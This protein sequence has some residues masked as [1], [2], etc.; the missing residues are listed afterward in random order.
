VSAKAYAEEA[1]RIPVAAECDVLVAGGGSAGIAAAVAASRAGAETILVERYGSLGGMATGGLVILLLSLDD[2]CG[3]QTVGGLCQELVDR[4]TARS[5]ALH[6][7]AEQWGNPDLELVEHYR[8][9]GLVWGREP[10]AV[11]YSVAYDPEEFRFAA[12]GLLAEAGV[13]LRL[14]TWI[15]RPIV[16]DGAVQGVIT[17]SKAGREAFLAKVVVDATGDGDLFAAAGE[18]FGLEQVHPWLWFRMGNVR[19]ADDAILGTEGRFFKALGGRFFKTLGAGRTLMPWGIADVVDRKIDPTSPDDLTWA[20]L[21]CRRRVMAVVDELK[22]VEGFEDAYLE[23]LA[24]QLGIYE[25]RRLEGRYVLGR[26]DEGVS[27]DD[28]VAFTGDWVRY[29]VTY[30]IPYR[31]LLPQRTEQ[32]LVA[33]RCLSADH[34]VHQATKEIPPCF[35]TG[36]AAGIAA[37]LSAATGIATSSLDVGE[38]RA[39]LLKAGAILG[40]NDDSPSSDGGGS[41]AG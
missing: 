18:P 24:W 12:N 6:P 17:E 19:G 34:R 40:P 41:D 22:G 36:E 39:Q 3:R 27:F 35:A 33:G 11:R 1:R 13:R 37:A 9:Y 5:A 20:E 23:D 10:H 21:E 32:L 30:E 31:C 25:S 28:A 15:A 16:A 2:G 14:H 4:L 26:R 7:P 38:I 29:G 8:R